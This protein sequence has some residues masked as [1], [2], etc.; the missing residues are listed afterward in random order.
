[1]GSRYGAVAA[2]RDGA[3]SYTEPILS[4]ASAPLMAS[5]RIAFG[6]FPQFPRVLDLL[7]KRGA[8]V[9]L[10]PQSMLALQ[11]GPQAATIID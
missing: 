11:A 7:F 1:M 10:P 6:S 5:R 3:D 9:L 4:P 2:G 8:F